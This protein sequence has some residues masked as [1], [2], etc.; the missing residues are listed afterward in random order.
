MECYAVTKNEQLL[1]L[2][3]YEI[4]SKSWGEEWKTTQVICNQMWKKHIYFLQYV[5]NTPESPLKEAEKQGLPRGR[6]A[7]GQRDG[8]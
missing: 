2:H 5:E 7:G 3:I 4:I 1:F 6:E 8:R